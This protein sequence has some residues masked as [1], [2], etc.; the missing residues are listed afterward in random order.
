MHILRLVPYM[1]LN[2]RPAFQRNN[3]G[4]GRSVWD[5]SRY[6]AA[7]DEE[8]SVFTYVP[9]EAFSLAGVSFMG[10]N[11]SKA[12]SHVRPY[13]CLEALRILRYYSHDS[14][15][16]VAKMKYV[17]KQCSKGYLAGQIRQGQFDIIHVHGVTLDTVPFLDAAI[18][19]NVPMVVTMHGMYSLGAP[20]ATWFNAIL[21][22]LLV[23]Y[24]NHQGICITT[25]SSGIR[26]TIIDSFD[27]ARPDRIKV[28]L[29]G[30]DCDKF[31][32]SDPKEVLRKRYG[33]LSEKAVLLTVGSLTKIKNQHLVLEALLQ[34]PEN[35]R[36]CLHY[37]IVGD[38][39]EEHYLREFVQQNRLTCVQFLGYRDGNALIDIYNLADAF[40]F[41][42]PAIGYPRMF[43]EAFSAGTPVLAFSD[44][45][46]LNDVYSSRA[47]ELIRDRTAQAVSD[48][49]VRAVRTRW[50]REMIRCHAQNFSWSQIA[51]D[52]RAVY[53]NE[54]ALK[55]CMRQETRQEAHKNVTEYLL[56]R[57][58][59]AVESGRET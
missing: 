9:T 54:I 43:L 28:V 57:M 22:R 32:S 5:I 8:V 23:E 42:S 20:S 10:F 30:V 7:L 38:G 13:D 14:R 11:L 29:N 31:R 53:E 12:I 4:F 15:G 2:D 59:H 19:A 48:A 52:Y 56:Y 17:L 16:I 45:P 21:E 26:H 46:G 44:L 47:M 36:E 6:S 39:P 51:K 50:D 24:L 1:Y 41:T 34:V 37:L 58:A 18:E 35:A 55:R 40:V 3:N 49:I 27:I 25:V 33:L